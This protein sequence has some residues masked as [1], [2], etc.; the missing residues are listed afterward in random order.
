[1]DSALQVEDTMLDLRD[2]GVEI[3]TFGQYLQAR[4]LQGLPCPPRS[5][6]PAPAGASGT[7]FSTLHG[8]PCAAASATCPA[9]RR[10]AL[11]CLALP[12]CLPRLL[13]PTPHHLPVK[14]MVTPEK[15]EHW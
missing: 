7:C 14:E 1:M 2:A 9:N 4:A 8:M 5:P 3:L 15:F 11:M 6:W 10:S 12:T 13:Q